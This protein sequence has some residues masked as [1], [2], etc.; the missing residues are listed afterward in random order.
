MSCRQSGGAQSPCAHGRITNSLGSELWKKAFCRKVSPPAT[1]KTKD[2]SS[3]G[4][5]GGRE[6]KQL[7]SHAFLQ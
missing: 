4:I 3:G 7:E 2:S 1:P 6:K 5:T